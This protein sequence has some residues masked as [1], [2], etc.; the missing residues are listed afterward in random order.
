MTQGTELTVKRSTLGRW[1][2]CEAGFEKALADFD[3]RDDAIHYA[4]GIASTRPRASIDA[5]PDDRLPELRE[6]YALDP[7]SGKSQRLDV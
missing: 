3:T 1:E 6:R 2:V 7:V 5:E 4:R